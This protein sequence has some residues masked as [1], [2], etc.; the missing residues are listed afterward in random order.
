[1]SIWETMH[2]VPFRGNF[3]GESSRKVS[4]ALIRLDFQ[5]Q[6]PSKQLS[7]FFPSRSQPISLFFLKMILYLYLFSH[8]F[9][10]NLIGLNCQKLCLCLMLLCIK[11][12]RFQS[13]RLHI[14]IKTSID[15]IFVSNFFKMR[16]IRFYCSQQLVDWLRN[17]KVAYACSFF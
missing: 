17:S 15:K 7:D 5:T 13:V 9:F 11:T 4:L 2:I 10:G 8:S 16:N 3:M 1:M 14:F 6:F 12:K